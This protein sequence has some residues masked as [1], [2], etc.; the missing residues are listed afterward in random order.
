MP[1]QADGHR[2]FVAVH[3]LGNH[4]PIFRLKRQAPH[5]VHGASCSNPNC[6]CSMLTFFHSATT[7]MPL[8]HEAQ[9]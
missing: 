1:I 7:A 4:A 2:F 9:G 5:S 6:T 8:S 3:H